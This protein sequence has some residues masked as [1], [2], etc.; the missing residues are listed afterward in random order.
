MTEPLI[1]MIVPYY[2]QPK[3]LAKQLETWKYYSAAVRNAL[4]FVARIGLEVVEMDKQDVW[5]V[6]V[7]PERGDV[8]EPILSGTE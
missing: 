7:L 1:T 3:M 8:R 6:T 5:R 4:D 2:R